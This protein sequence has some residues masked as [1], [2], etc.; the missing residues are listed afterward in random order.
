M[1]GVFQTRVRWAMYVEFVSNINAIDGEKVIQMLNKSLNQRAAKLE[2]IT[3]V[4]GY[5]QL[6]SF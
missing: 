6:I 4:Y 1:P 5:V 3:Y 2:I